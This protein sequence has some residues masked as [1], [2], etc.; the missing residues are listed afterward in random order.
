MQFTI[1]DYN[2]LYIHTDK[3]IT[4][5][6]AFVNVGSI[7]EK[8]EQSGIAHILEH[9]LLDGWSHCKDN[10]TEYWSYKGVN[11][12]G[13]TMSCYTTYYILGSSTKN[14]KTNGNKI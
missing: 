10:C 7:H 9:I 6:Q 4:E 3:N 8:Y 14:D 13:H 1:N 2:V 5:I 11:S 12:N